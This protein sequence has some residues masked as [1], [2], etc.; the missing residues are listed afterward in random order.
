[1]SFPT[2]GFDG[3]NHTWHSMS[4][5]IRRQAATVYLLAAAMVHVLDRT[6]AMAQPPIPGGFS[7][8]DV[9]DKQV[10]AAAEAAAGSK[11]ATL[12]K[13]LQARQQVVA[14]M[15]YQLVLRVRVDGSERDAEVA[16]YR[17][18]KDQ[19]DVTSWRWL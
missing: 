6:A 19:Y 10:I 17:N 15:N 16:V 14:G 5:K 4:R 12:V 8:A 3:S 2:L 11:S 18:L 1:M 9:S 13:I 7:A